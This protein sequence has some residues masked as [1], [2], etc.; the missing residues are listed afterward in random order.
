MED[1][2]SMRATRCKYQHSALDNDLAAATS[3]RSHH[4]EQPTLC[5]CRHHITEAS[6]SLAKADSNAEAT[7]AITPAAIHNV[8]ILRD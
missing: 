1:H 5:C 6:C 4:R 7:A 8:L 3:V 2:T